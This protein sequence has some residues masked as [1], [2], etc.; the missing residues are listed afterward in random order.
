MITSHDPLVTQ[1]RL[2]EVKHKKQVLTSFEEQD[3]KTIQVAVEAVLNV[4]S[5]TWHST[6]S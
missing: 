5:L 4:A 3:L 1:S 2:F 6:T